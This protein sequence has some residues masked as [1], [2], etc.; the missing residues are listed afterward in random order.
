[1]PWIVLLVSA[2][3]EAVW[4]T[5][6]GHSEGFS[7]ITAST[8]FVVALVASLAGLGW[9]VRSISIGTAYAVWTGLGA[10]LTVGYAVVSGA[11][12]ASVWKLVFISGI[13]ASVAGLKLLPHEPAT[14]SAVTGHDGSAVSRR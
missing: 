4:A 1:V 7:D 10:A 9:A 13:V 3:L 14:A 2:V 12:S 6:L 8:V 11:E 5:A